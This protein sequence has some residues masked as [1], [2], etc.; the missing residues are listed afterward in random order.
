[1]R[2]AMQAI[3]FQVSQNGE[4]TGERNLTPDELRASREQFS[5]EFNEDCSLKH[6]DFL[7]HSSLSES[8]ARK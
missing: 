1:M 3:T 8:T 5:E 6:F 4:I 7:K 2:L